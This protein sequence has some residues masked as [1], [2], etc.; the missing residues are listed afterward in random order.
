MPQRN[1]I[2]DGSDALTLNN[3]NRRGE[4]YGWDRGCGVIIGG[5]TSAI[6]LQVASGRVVHDG[7]QLS[8]SGGAVTLQPG[9]PVNPRKDLIYVD[10]EGAIRVKQGRP[11][12]P[13]PEDRVG[14]KTWQ[15]APPDSAALDA[16]PLAEIWVPPGATSSGDLEPRFRTD[17]RIKAGTGGGAI[18]ALSSDP[19]DEE[20]LS[21]RQWLNTTAGEIRVYREDTNEVHSVNTTLVRTI[22][23]PSERVVEPFDESINANWRGGGSEYTFNTPAFEGNAA[24][25][26][27]NNT[28]TRDYSLP[29][30]GLSYYASSGDRISI[31]VRFDST[32]A[33]TMWFTFGRESDDYYSGNRVRLDPDGLLRLQVADDSNNFDTLGSVSV[34]VSWPNWYILETDYDGGGEGVHPSRIYST[35]SGAR[36]T[37]LGEITSPTASTAHR[38]RGY[39]ITMHGGSGEVRA[40]RLAVTPDGA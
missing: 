37:M 2:G 28:W 13:L 17:R 20:L 18:P 39:G 23:A 5:S 1:F 8:V 33:R 6:E 40:D 11:A 15:P 29:G 4:G 36:D 30:D 26:W 7:R 32:N 25:A 38:G 34:S 12:P 22:G 24:A 14:D 9:D 21:T 27:S 35:A 10:R 3:L 16:V 19:P 31:A